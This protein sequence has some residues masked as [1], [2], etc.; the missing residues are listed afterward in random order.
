MAKKIIRE[1][2]TRNLL[3]CNVK[4]DITAE[5]I[6]NDL[7]HIDR[8]EVLSITP[9]GN[10]IIVSLNAIRHALTART[11]MWSQLR[12]KNI[13]IQ[14]APDNC[15]QDLPMVEERLERAILNQSDR[16]STQNRFDVFSGENNNTDDDE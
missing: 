8:L 14:F 3:L 9:S 16:I 6:R 4:S 13:P 7:G 5:A 10:D 2:A 1:N 15:E 12:Y 11:C